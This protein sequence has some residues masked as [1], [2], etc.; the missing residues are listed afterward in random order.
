MHGVIPDSG[1]SELLSKHLDQKTAPKKKN[2]TAA[3]YLDPICI[4]TI[5]L[6]LDWRLQR[7][8]KRTSKR[9]EQMHQ[10]QNAIYVYIILYYIIFH[11]IISYYIML[12]YIIS[13]HIILYCIILYYIMLYC[14]MLRYMCIMLRIIL[15]HIILYH[16]ISYHIILYYIISYY[17]IL[18]YIIYTFTIVYVYIYIYIVQYVYICHSITRT[19]LQASCVPL[20]GQL[21]LKSHQKMLRGDGVANPCGL[22]KVRS[23]YEYEYFTVSVTV[24]VIN[25]A[26]DTTVLGWAK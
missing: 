16:I 10:N 24:R 2:K 9:F 7:Q 12:C 11:Y 6:G 19:C 26:F 14:V 15:Y 5:A 25:K 23:K 1:K 21:R 8:G 22:V 18:Y 4:N 13:Y 20:F 17:I 3:E